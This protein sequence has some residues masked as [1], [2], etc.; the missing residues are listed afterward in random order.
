MIGEMT[1]RLA[2]GDILYDGCYAHIISRSIRK[3]KIFRNRRDFESFQEMLLKAKK[4]SGCKIYHYCLMHT[5]F[6]LAVE[7]PDVS[8]FS[9]A[10]QNLK[11]RYIYRFHEQ[12]KTSGP[13]WWERYKSLLIEN[14]AY[15]YAC[16]QYIEDNPVRAGVV[17][18]QQ[19]W[20]YSS[21]RYYAQGREDE[22]VDG[23]EGAETPVMPE[24]VDIHNKGF[25]ERGMGIGSGFFRFQLAEKLKMIRKGGI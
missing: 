4:E 24:A 17:G 1:A 16:G 10:I 13:I 23:Y 20:E 8:R 5:H 25:F 18:A 12:Y 21:S 19:D 15:M 2:R 7:M 14:E 3:L 9:K 11:S 22:L 6:H